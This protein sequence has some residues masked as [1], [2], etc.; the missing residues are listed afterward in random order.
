M[1]FATFWVIKKT[2]L[3]TLAFA[4]T[5]AQGCQ[6]VSFQTKNLNLGKFWRVL[7]WKILLYFMAVWSVLWSFGI[8]CGHLVYF[9]VIWYILWSFGK[10]ST[11]LVRCTKKN[12]ATLQQRCVLADFGGSA[13]RN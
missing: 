4:A 13:F 9:I 2:H 1:V 3:V 10:F 12:L 8:L 6:M 11:V 5:T 7:E